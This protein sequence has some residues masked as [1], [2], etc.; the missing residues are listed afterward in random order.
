M[1]HDG[2]EKQYPKNFG[3]NGNSSQLLKKYRNP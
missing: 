1:N 3:K 2:N